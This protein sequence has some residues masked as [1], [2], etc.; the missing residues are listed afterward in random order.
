MWCRV[1]ISAVSKATTNLELHFFNNCF[2]D[3]YTDCKLKR[4]TEKLSCS[5]CILYYTP[6]SVDPVWKVARYTSA[7]PM[8]F[9]ECDNYIDGGVICN[10]PTEYGLT[11]I[12][13]FVRQQGKRLPIGLVVSIG[14]GVY[15]AK[16][17]GSIDLFYGNQTFHL[18][19]IM[20][21]TQNLISLLANAVSCVILSIARK[22]IPFSS[23][24]VGSDSIANGV[25]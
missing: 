15:P 18:T 10:N 1:L 20:R 6:T 7:T 19:G 11:A 2:Q 13:N 23:I 9:S 4:L 25:N 21:R 16:E 14:T 8:F 3:G 5:P 17:L 12:Q 22:L 24:S